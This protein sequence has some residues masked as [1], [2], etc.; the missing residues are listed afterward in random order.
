MEDFISCRHGLA[1]LQLLSGAENIEKR[2]KMPS[3]W[4]SEQY[5]DNRA[6]REYERNHLLGEVPDSMVEFDAFYNER[7]ARLKE[8]IGR[9][10]G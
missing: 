8:R 1:N 10:L 3:R 4:L 9:L 5:P 7:R 2:T 6:R